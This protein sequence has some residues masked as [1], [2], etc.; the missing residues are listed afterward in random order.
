MIHVLSVN[1][2]Y[3]D[4]LSLN[5]GV[6]LTP[7]PGTL[8]PI[9]GN[10][11]ELDQSFSDLNRGRTLIVSGKPV[12]V[13]ADQSFQLITDTNGLSSSIRQGV[14]LQVLHPPTVITS[15]QIRWHL[16]ANDGTVGY[17]TVSRDALVLTAALE[18]DDLVSEAI[19]LKNVASN[20]SRLELDQPLRHWYDR[21]TVVLYGNA[22]LTTH[23]E[24][25]E[26]V[27][28]SG[29]AAQAF[30]TFTLR[31]SP[32]THVS[33]PTATGAASTLELRV[34]DIRWQEVPA[35]FGQGSDQRVFSTAINEDGKTVIQFGDGH[36]MGARLPS[37]L[38]S[39]RG[40]YRQGLG[41]AG[42][43][44]SG[45]LSLLLKRPLGVKSC[46][47]PAPASGGADPP[48]K[49]S[50]QQD[51]PTTVLTLGRIVSRR[52]YED[53]ARTFAGIAKALATELGTST[54]T[55]AITL[56]GTG[57]QQVASGGTLFQNLLQAMARSGDPFVAVRLMSY[58]PAYFRLAATL[59]VDPNYLPNKVLEQVRNTL[60]D[61]FSF[62]ARSLGQG[63]GRSE[64]I[65][66]MQAVEGVVAVDL[67]LLYRSG[68]KPVSQPLLRAELP[69]P[70]STPASLT[71]AELLLL[72]P[73]SLEDVEVQP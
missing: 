30:Q 41:T 62:A 68:Q 35:L 9:T 71:A 51:V 8:T 29:D 24:T 3:T 14:L 2:P 15:R 33:A 49:N 39:I 72:D 17:A 20:A 27:L 47:N 70:G 52:D 45:Q 53:F 61:T 4:P 25:K 19:T 50:L 40:R 55:I 37:G 43:V 67:D 6:R 66:V 65:A 21:A 38:E 32:L 36:Q 57:G 64:V 22:A 13:R 26:E 42:N 11:I 23:G 73:N 46:I 56:A 44:K 63:V 34:N 28:G 18:E 48:D 16:K 54:R 31:S 59:K 7:T 10:A 69:R 60:K 58:R 12:R 5:A 1:Q